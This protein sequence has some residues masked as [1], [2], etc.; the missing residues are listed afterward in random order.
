MRHTKSG[1]ARLVYCVISADGI[2][3]D[4]AQQ[5]WHHMSD[6]PD[7]TPGV[8]LEWAAQQM[9]GK[10]RW[11]NNARKQVEDNLWLRANP[12]PDGMRCRALCQLHEIIF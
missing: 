10:V 2:V 6:I 4:V 5:R 7:H 11:T 1:G 12:Q 9:L 8:L 3:T